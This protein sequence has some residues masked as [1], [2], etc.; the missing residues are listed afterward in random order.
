MFRCEFPLT[1]FPQADYPEIILAKSRHADLIAWSARQRQLREAK[2]ARRG[3]G[4]QSR[5]PLLGG[6]LSLIAPVVFFITR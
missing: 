5:F 4:G 1:D 2:N 6:I 3:Q